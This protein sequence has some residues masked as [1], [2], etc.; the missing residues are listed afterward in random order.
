MN[1]S[2]T[3]TETPLKG[4]KNY[5]W[6]VKDARMLW[7]TPTVRGTR[8]HVSQILECLAAGMS[9]DEIADD[10]PGFP[11]ECIPEV[12]RFAAEVVKDGDV[13]A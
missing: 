10:Y 4:Y 13:A 1:L 6:I 7:G 12:L 5:K 8:L 3:D 9:A 2:M 11:Q